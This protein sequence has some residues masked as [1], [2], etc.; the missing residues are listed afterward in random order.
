MDVRDIATG[1]LPKG[2]SS[3][4]AIH[5]LSFATETKGLREANPDAVTR[6]SCWVGEEE[7]ST[8]NEGNVED[9]IARSTED[10]LSEDHSECYSH[11]DHP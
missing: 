3:R 6:H 7:E 5:D 8:G 1:D 2:C 11:S 9:V 10:F 4:E